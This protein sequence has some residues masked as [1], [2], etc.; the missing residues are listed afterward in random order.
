MDHNDGLN[1]GALFSTSI[2]FKLGQLKF[3]IFS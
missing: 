1:D 2:T 3:Y